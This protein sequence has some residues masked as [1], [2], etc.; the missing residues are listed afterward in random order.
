MIDIKTPAG[1]PPRDLLDRVLRQLVGKIAIRASMPGEAV[2]PPQL[3]PSILAARV[4]Q[5]LDDAGELVEA[6]LDVADAAV[7]SAVRVLAC[8]EVR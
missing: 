1:A 8:E 7:A 5:E 3:Q 2:R 4:A 6:L